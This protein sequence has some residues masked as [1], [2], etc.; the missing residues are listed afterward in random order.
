MNCTYTAQGFLACPNVNVKKITGQE[1]IEGFA[2]AQSV[3]FPST[4][5]GNVL[6]A[7]KKCTVVKNS[8][9]NNNK[10][11]LIKCDCD[12]CEDT[13]RKTKVAATSQ[14]LISIRGKPINWCGTSFTNNACPPDSITSLT[15]CG[16]LAEDSQNQN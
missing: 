7:C 6:Q 15:R 13:E 11:C 10:D 16:I 5:S 2:V 14:Q 8:C 3:A 9:K 12:Y 4:V 1:N